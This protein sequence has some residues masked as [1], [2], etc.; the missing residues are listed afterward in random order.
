MMNYKEL[1]EHYY[2]LFKEN[3]PFNEN[4]MEI[5]VNKAEIIDK[6]KLIYDFETRYDSQ[7]KAHNNEKD[8]DF[9]FF[10]Q[11]LNQ[12]KGQQVVC[13]LVLA[14][15]HYLTFVFDRD[16]SNLLCVF[17][18]NKWKQLVEKDGS[19]PNVDRVT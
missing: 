6:A 14:K 3:I 4:D 16:K 10:F 1:K 7:L 15:K 12:F 8:L 5:E 19:V 9:E 17:P 2:I 18:I 11:S 13:L